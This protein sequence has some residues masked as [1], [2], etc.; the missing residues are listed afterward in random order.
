MS[1]RTELMRWDG[2]RWRAKIT[3]A[4]TPE[5]Y[6]K[7]YRPSPRQLRKRYP[8]LVTDLDRDGSR[9]AANQFWHDLQSEIQKSKEVRQPTLAEL[10]RKNIEGK[11]TKAERTKLAELVNASLDRAREVLSGVEF[12]SSKT[13]MQL[14]VIDT[15]IGATLNNELPAKLVPTD[16]TVAFWR[17]RW[18]AK[19]KSEL[20]PASYNILPNHVNKFVDHVGPQVEVTKVDSDAVESFKM[21]LEGWI[22]D[23]KISTTYA[24]NIATS[25]KSFVRYLFKRDKIPLP[26]N[27]DE[28]NFDTEE[29]LNPLTLDEA[30]ELIGSASGELRCWILTMF[31]ICCTQK[32]LN[33]LKNTELDWDGGFI[34]RKRSKTHKKKNTP[35]VNHRLWPETLALLKEHGTD[36]GEF[37]LSKDGERL[38]NGRTDRVSTSFKKHITAKGWNITPK[39]I[40]KTVA[41]LLGNSRFRP[42]VDFYGGWSPT[43]VL[44]KHYLVPSQKKLDEMVAWLGNQ[45]G[46]ESSKR[47][48]TK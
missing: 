13:E 48:R 37:V 30:K 35:L 15:V 17:D 9:R 23:K 42:W 36:K 44:E 11:T 5:K 34:K 4:E 32:D 46:V 12:S 28:F 22:E 14:K 19:R 24:D 39:Q 6:R 45:L 8:D 27:L 7:E 47:A 18:L 16:T 38:L 29:R 43:S 20:N 2:V 25:V 1:A 10:A 21:K 33:D 41:T 40:R 26:K 3:S 31:N